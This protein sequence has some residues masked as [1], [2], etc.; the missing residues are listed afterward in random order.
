MAR[1]TI[2]E[3]IQVPKAILW[4]ITQ[5]RDDSGVPLAGG[6]LK[7]YEKGTSTLQKTYKDKLATVEHDTSVR[8]DS[9]GRVNLYLD[10]S[11]PS[12]KIEV[13]DKDD[14]LI[15]TM[16]DVNLNS[17]YAPVE[18][19]RSYIGSI[20][21]DKLADANIFTGYDVYEM[22]VETDA[23]TA[24][25]TVQAYDDKV[26][27]GTGSYSYSYKRIN[28]SGTESLLSTTAGSRL[29]FLGFN[30]SG[31]DKNS[32]GVIVGDILISV[33]TIGQNGQV[34][35]M[36]AA[37]DYPQVVTNLSGL[38]FSITTPSKFKVHVYGVNT[39]G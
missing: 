21:I 9:A 28:T 5:W 26:L 31:S 36:I 12:Y 35:N 37:A 10:T 13:Y 16:L 30:E 6:Y 23:S 8:L 32:F 25:P 34:T 24:V 39:S 22:L 33:G 18:G 14:S 15:R 17:A 3:C 1:P 19:G 27:V 20:S 4:P 7:T 2:M 38:T 29:I 11:L